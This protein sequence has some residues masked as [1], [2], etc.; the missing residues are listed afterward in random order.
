VISATFINSAFLVFSPGFVKQEF[1]SGATRANL[2]S[3]TYTNAPAFVSYLT[4]FETPSGQGS[5]YAERVSGFFIAP[6]TTNYV[7]YLASDDDSDLFLST[8]ASPTNK[9]IIA[10]ETKWSNSR[11]WFTSGGGSVLPS[12]RSDQFTGTTWPTGN[13][14]TLTGGVQYYLEADHHQGSGGDGFAAT[15]KFA[16]APDPADGSVPALT[17]GL[18]AVNAYNNTYITITASPRNAA[19]NPGT[20]A[21]FAVAAFS[22]YLGD[23]S[24]LVAPPISYQ[25]QS[26]PFGVSSFTNI[27]N[28]TTNSFTTSFLTTANDGSQYRVALATVGFATNSAAARLTV[29]QLRF[30]GISLSAGQVFLQ[31][32][33][34]ALLQEATNLAG[35][36]TASANQNNPQTT[37]VSGVRFYRLR[38]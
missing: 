8:D 9:H 22:G 35:P 37:P 38:Q 3:G 21:T 25:W 24:G 1:Y 27:S 16:G 30:T 4:S 5:S 14:I 10:Q 18:L 36:W 20:N 33:G 26:A 15:F 11:N 7:F 32:S 17:S 12:K 34:N 19:V 13:T 28:A 29:G 31:W 2:E 23:P 6:L